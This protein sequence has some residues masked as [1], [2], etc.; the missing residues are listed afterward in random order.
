MKRKLNRKQVRYILLQEAK[1]EILLERRKR[2][3]YVEVIDRVLL[4]NKNLI[5][6]KY[7]HTKEINEGLLDS[8]M[9]N[10][11]LVIFQLWDN[12]NSLSSTYYEIKKE[13]KEFKFSEFLM[14]IRLVGV[15][16][17]VY[18]LALKLSFVF[19]PLLRKLS[20]RQIGRNKCIII[21][22]STMSN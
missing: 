10:G 18:S 2:K 13:F 16:V 22:R 14:P 4:E 3:K 17:P 7:L 1:K 6:S 12:E 9:D 5:N 19:R 20:G 8:L 15:Y 21:E 11:K